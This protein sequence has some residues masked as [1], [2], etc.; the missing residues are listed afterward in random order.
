MSAHLT[1]GTQGR[2]P[3]ETVAGVNWQQIETPRGEPLVDPQA[4]TRAAIRHPLEFPDLAQAIV[5]GDQIAVALAPGVVE[6]AAITAGV[7]Q[8]LIAAGAEP[9][10]ITVVSTASESGD[11]RQKLPGMVRGRVQLERHDP[12]NRDRLE[13]LA[14]NRKGRTIYFN[15]TLCDADLLITIGQ[16]PHGPSYADLGLHTG[17]FPDFSDLDSQ[18]RYRNLKL[19]TAVAEHETADESDSRMLARA[20]FEVDKIG[21]IAGAVFT[22][23]TVPAGPDSVMDV[24]A[25]EP[26]SVE[27]ELRRRN[28]AAWSVERSGGSDLVV[29]ALSGGAAQQTWSQ[30]V[31]ALTAADRLLDS[32]GAIALCTELNVAPA[33]GVSRLRPQQRA[34]RYEAWLNEHRPLDT[35]D[36]WFLSRLLRRRKVF[37][38]SGLEPD[39][40]EALGIEPLAAVDEL[41]RLMQ[42]YRRPLVLPHAQFV[43]G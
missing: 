14:A 15:R 19:V 29:A 43:V 25:G 9:D 38:L 39:T 41:P 16:A 10:S 2:V 21:W 26:S 1:Y 5:P 17:L 7:V 34:E 13:F 4:A 3:L 18:R 36:A 37:L 30:V 20:R 8:E 33:E 11:P 24:V 28:Q 40:V 42:R 32:D 22:V 31:R 35:L 23:Q 12:S 6:S 27:R